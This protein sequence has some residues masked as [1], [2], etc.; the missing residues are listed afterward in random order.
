[1]SENIP[2]G[3]VNLLEMVVRCFDCWLSCAAHITVVNEDGKEIYSR[4]LN[5]GLGWL[6]NKNTRLAK[7]AL[8]GNNQH[9]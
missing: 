1:M 5:V 2:E 6:S 4:K 9:I 8:W 7:T 3:M